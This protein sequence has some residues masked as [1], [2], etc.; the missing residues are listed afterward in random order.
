MNPILAIVIGG[1]VGFL[2]ASQVLRI[3]N[4][5][6][7]VIAS[8]IGAV[9][10]VVS[11]FLLAGLLAAILSIIGQIALVGVGAYFAVWGLKQANVLK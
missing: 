3:D 1:V 7:L 4:P 11:F 2:T 5:Q 10:G 6:N 9:G 8:V